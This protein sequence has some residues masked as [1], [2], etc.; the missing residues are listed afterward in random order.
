MLSASLLVS[1]G[2]ILEL[3]GALVGGRGGDLHDLTLGWLLGLLIETAAMTPVVFRALQIGAAAQGLAPRCAPQPAYVP[4]TV[5]AG[6]EYF[7]SQGLE[8]PR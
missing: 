8:K 6:S 1:L 3:G 4:A 2:C 5:A 7:A